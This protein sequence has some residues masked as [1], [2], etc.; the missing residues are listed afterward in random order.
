M[1]W[2]SWLFFC[3]IVIEAIPLSEN[4]QEQAVYELIGRM[5]SKVGMTNQSYTQHLQDSVDLLV[6]EKEN[7]HRDFWIVKNGN[8]EGR[9]LVEG[10]SGTALANG[11][12]M[13]ESDLRIIQRYL[14]YYCNTTLSWG[15]DG[16]GDH[17]SI[18]SPLPSLP[19]P[20]KEEVRFRCSMNS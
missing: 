14:K 4:N 9:I 3:A 19:A 1:R 20:W 7:P 12:Y 6:V 16:T 15:E 17:I 2:L 8:Q 11:L 18:P 10:T 5:F 13:Y